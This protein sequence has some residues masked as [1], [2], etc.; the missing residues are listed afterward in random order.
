MTGEVPA[1]E[2][3]VVDARGMLCPVPIIRLARA[4][5]NLPAGSLIELLTDDPAARFDVPAWCHLRG[6]E[7]LATEEAVARTGAGPGLRHRIRLVGGPAG[8]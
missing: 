4:A 8:P 6:H 5:A 1:G 7:L 2:L 3:V